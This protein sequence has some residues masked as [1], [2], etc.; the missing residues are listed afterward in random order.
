M[1]VKHSVEQCGACGENALIETRGVLEVEYSGEKEVISQRSHKCESCGAVLF[2]ESDVR[3][4]RRTWLRFKKNI[5]GAPLGCEIAAMRIN[6]NLTQKAAGDL[7][8][9]GPVAF[10]KYENDDLVPDEAMINLLRLAIAFPDTIKRLVAVKQKPVRIHILQHIAESVKSDSEPDD[11]F[12][13]ADSL[14][15]NLDEQN[16]L[17]SKFSSQHSFT[18]ENSWTLH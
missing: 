10:S 14:G 2:D 13:M 8:G 6:A 11:S 18:Q 17:L 16:K 3:E 5:D 1:S 9:G 7:F 12:E 4:N 15:F